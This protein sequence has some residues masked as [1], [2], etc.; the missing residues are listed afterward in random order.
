MF[1]RFEALVGG[2]IVIIYT[3]HSGPAVLQLHSHLPF[4]ADHSRSDRDV[5]RRAFDSGT[6]QICSTHT[7]DFRM[8]NQ[9]GGW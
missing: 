1:D 5:T 2:V 6:S 9:K 7:C 3:S 8:G 4:I